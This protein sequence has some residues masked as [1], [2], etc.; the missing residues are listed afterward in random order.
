MPIPIPVTSLYLAV[1]AVFGAAL[2]FGPGRLRGQTGVSI[3]DGGNPQLLLAMRRHGNFVEF[4]PYFMTMLLALELNGASAMSLHGLGGAMVLA[5]IA[6][7]MGLKA[8]TI[9]AP[10]RAVGAAGTML[11]TMIAALMLLVQAF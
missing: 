5:R 6:H 2:A 3:G 11:L 4:V 7:V 9:E 8:D 10:L 1:F